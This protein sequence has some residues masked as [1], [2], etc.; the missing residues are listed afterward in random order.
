[1]FSMSSR[2]CRC[3]HA[4][5]HREIELRFL[6]PR[7]AREAIEAE[8]ARGPAGLDRRRLA[9]M[10]LDTAD[11][12]LARAGL[13]WRLRRE[14]RLWVQTLKAGSADALERFEHEVPRPADRPD[15]SLHAGTPPG[16]RL[17]DELR[18]AHADGLEPTVR[19]RTEV[20]RTVRR[21]RTRGAVVDVALD[22]GRIV[23]PN[24]TLRIAEIEFE[25][26]SGSTV[27]MLAL[28][29]RW[30]ERFGLVFE[31]R[32]K[33]ER[34]DR[35]AD[36]ARFPAVRKASRPDYDSDTGA[37]EAFGTV[38]DECMAQV[39]RNAIGVIQGD[40]Q[41]RVDHVHQLRVG[42]RRLR[43]AL[44]SFQGW[45]PA[46]PDDG[47]DGL[48]ALFATLGAARD[49]DVLGSG[50]HAELAAAGAPPLTLPQGPEAPSPAKVLAASQTQQRLLAWLTWRAALTDAPTLVPVALV[51]VDA[52][53]PPP[54]VDAA[55]ALG[56]RAAARLRRWHK[57]IV[58]D[59][60]A[61]DTLSEVELHA[62]RK[63]I[64]RQR[65]AAE[66]FAPVL[67]RRQVERYL[68]ALSA[69]QE[70]MGEMN[71][72]VV[73]RDRYQS[74]ATGEPGAWFALGWLS[75]RI[76]ERRALVQPDLSRLAK[77][78]PPAGR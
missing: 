53:A 71:D 17:L 45:A 27:A 10:Y 75:A 5:A 57:R 3:H 37:I 11:R 22:E 78:A 49:T 74:A 68:D 77:T 52:T 38:F 58:A 13:S 55:V 73:A 24:G 59:A 61:F 67:R 4:V 64:K 62:L 41:Q 14:G 42:I 1:M 70:R 44:R 8:L 20:R 34:G 66:F 46:P 9:A 40:P 51:P 35:L 16:D 47:V 12:R 18:R 2:A 19:F 56:D 28:V 29:G 43:T 69:V 31:P 15:P 39:T 33:A 7:G 60:K 26:A 32:S 63:R 36:G 23:T 6:V 30:L 48:R 25:K 76:A 65:Y 54:S 50:V 72:L 21:V